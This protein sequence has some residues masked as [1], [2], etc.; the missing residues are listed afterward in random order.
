M[1]VLVNERDS[2]NLT[3]TIG[4]WVDVLP[5]ASFPGGPDAITVEGWIDDLPGD[6]FLQL[7]VDGSSVDQEN[8]NTTFW[9]D[10]LATGTHTVKLQAM[11]PSDWV[12]AA[13]VVTTRGLM[14]TT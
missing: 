14:V 3:L 4:S 9:S 6:C 11:V 5:Q 7:L 13:P 1:T 2:S 8:G 12:G 10:F